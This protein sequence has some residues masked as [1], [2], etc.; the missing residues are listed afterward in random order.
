[1]FFIANTVIRKRRPTA[2]DFPLS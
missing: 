1:M 2:T